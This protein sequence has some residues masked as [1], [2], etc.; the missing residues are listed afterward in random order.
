MKCF[1]RRRYSA[2]LAIGCGLDF[3]SQKGGDIFVF[4]Q[5]HACWLSQPSAVAV[6]VKVKATL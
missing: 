2:S 4:F 3:V 6:K 5:R 1:V